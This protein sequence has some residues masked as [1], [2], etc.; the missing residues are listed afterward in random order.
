[1]AVVVDLEK[2]TG[3]GNCEEACPTGAIKV[4]DG[5]AKVNEDDCV[6]CGA[7]VSECPTG[8]LSL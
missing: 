2:C 3:C 7:C 1:M 4:V 6:E 5:K 8:A